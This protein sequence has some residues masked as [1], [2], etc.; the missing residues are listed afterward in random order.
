[1][2]RSGHFNPGFKEASHVVQ[3][4]IEGIATQAGEDRAPYTKVRPGPGDISGAPRR[5]GGMLEGDCT[6][7]ATL[8]R[9]RD[10]LRRTRA[11]SAS[12]LNRHHERL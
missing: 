6:P 12:A 4:A 5:I 10:D 8:Y 3:R 2:T 1:M 11:R 9:R 7:S